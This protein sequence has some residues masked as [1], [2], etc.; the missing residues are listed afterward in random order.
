MGG[1]DMST[2]QG[3]SEIEQAQAVQGRIEGGMEGRGGIKHHTTLRG[4]G[5]LSYLKVIEEH[6]V[7]R[8]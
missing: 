8:R 5:D 6:F 4:K 3:W 7:M 2:K 1:D